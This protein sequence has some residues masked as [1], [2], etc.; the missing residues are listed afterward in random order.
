MITFI[1]LAKLGFLVSLNDGFA[2]WRQTIVLSNTDWSAIHCIITWDW[3]VSSKS[4]PWSYHFWDRR[5][6][7]PGIFGVIVMW[8]LIDNKCSMGF[9]FPTYSD[10]MFFMYDFAV[11]RANIMRF[12]YITIEI[13]QIT[14][15]RLARN[16]EVWGVFVYIKATPVRFLNIV[17]HLRAIKGTRQYLIS[18]ND[19]L[20]IWI[21]SIMLI[22][23]FV[24]FAY[25]IS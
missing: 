24:I 1:W 2:I 15:K 16:R 5:H 19:F 23:R 4:W 12:C 14:S 9:L 17:L 21:P 10:A 11:M 25:I 8:H 3:H 20:N 22:G 6:K 18:Y 7:D 13:L